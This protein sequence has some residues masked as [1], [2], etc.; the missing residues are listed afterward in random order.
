MVRLSIAALIYKSTR[1]ADWIYESLYEFTPHL[2]RNEAEFY[3]LAND[4][5]DNLLMHLQKKGY[6]HYVNYNEVLT[7]EQLFN[8][9]YGKPEYIHRVYR[10]WNQAI[11]KASGE[12][13]VLVNSD[14]YFS[15]DW[16]ENLLK[17]LTPQTIVCSKLVEREHPKHLVFKRA[18]HGEF[19]SHP[20]NFN[21]QAFLDFCDMKRI[22]GIEEGGAYMPCVF[23]KEAALRAGLYPEGNIAGK[24]FDDVV[25]Y[26]DRV[27]FRKLGNIGIRHITALDSLVYHL[28]EG[29]MES[30]S[31]DEIRE[32]VSVVGNGTE[33]NRIPVPREFMF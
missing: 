24:S 9:G 26:G 27:F 23:Y 25:D 4:P 31:T 10:G 12:I 18:Y 22:T 16:L 5:T 20:D 2:R 33:L 17:Y 8:M 1:F 7:E 32:T 3:F 11:T 14:N 21:K 13:V 19:G 30:A 29:E 6:K 28:K 15:P